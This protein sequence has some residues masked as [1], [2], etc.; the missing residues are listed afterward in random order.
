MLNYKWVLLLTLRITDAQKTQGIYDHDTGLNRYCLLISH[1][2][3]FTN[4]SYIEVH[5]SPGSEVRYI[6]KNRESTRQMELPS[7]PSR[8]QHWASRGVF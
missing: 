7:L 2:V 3:I 6:K 1:I 4:D 8:Y 5:I